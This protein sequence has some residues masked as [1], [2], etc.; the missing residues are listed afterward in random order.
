MAR[1]PVDLCE[2]RR[3]ADA[4]WSERGVWN[5]IYQDAYRFTTPYRRPVNGPSGSDK[6]ANRTDHLFD[7]TGVVSTFRGAGQM[8]QDLFPPGQVFFRLKPGPVTKLVAKAQARGMGDNGGPPLDDA[9]PAPEEK[10]DA[11]WFERQLDQVSAQIQPFFLSGEW[12]N[13]VSEL[14]LDLY[15]GTGVM[16]ILE[17]DRENPVRFVC[18]P[19]DEVALEPGPYGDVAA[20]FWRTKMTRRAI[21]AAFP[22][23]VF[24]QEFEDALEK[25]ADDEIDLSQD[26]VRTAKGWRLVVTIDKC[27]TPVTTQDYRT[28]PFVAARYFRVPGET[29]GRGPALLALPSIKTLNKVM[30]LTLKAAAIQM[31]GIWGYRPGGTFNPDQARIMPGAW[32]PMQ[33]TGGVMGPDVTR[34]DTAAG[35][36]DVANI[37]L[38]ELRTQVQAALHDQS[39]PDGGATP[40][41]ATEIMAR[42]ARVKQ[43]YVGAFGRMIHEVIPVVVRRVIEVLYKKGLLTVDVK[44][45]QLLVAIDVMSPLAQALKADTHKTTVEA[46]QMVAALEGPQGVARRFKLDE[47]IP[48]MVKDLGV[49][50]EYVRTAQELV[51]FDKQASAQQQAAAMMQAALNKPNDFRQALSPQEDQQQAAA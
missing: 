49:N 41:S 24:P 18:L 13:A 21:K 32:W 39:L 46:M 3:R 9:A 42:M 4:A 47:I 30:E 35:R 5:E 7:N 34:L 27:E 2:H 8:Q 22:K 51:D 14:C 17:G 37:V 15:L 12:D 19:I 1:A 25:N 36:L 26:F 40:K 48:E 6:G 11:A 50:S 38:Q 28:Q 16:L 29:M 45:D 10:R 23:G 20:L 33:A 44:I 31:L 43:N